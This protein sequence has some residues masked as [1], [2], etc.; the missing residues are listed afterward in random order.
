[1]ILRKDVV[2]AEEEKLAAERLTVA[3]KQLEDLS[4]FPLENPNPVLRVDRSGAIMFANAACAILDLKCQPGQFLPARYRKIVAEVLD[5]GSPQVIEAAGKG[6]IFTL[7]F[8]PVTTAGYVNIYGSDITAWKKAEEALR[9]NQQDLNRAQAVA[10]TGSWRLDVQR[11]ELLWSDETYRMFGI[12]KETPMTYETFL[13]CVHPDDRENVDR[14]WQAALQ[15]E[16]YDIE[17][18]IM[19]GD[20]VKWVRE[21]AEVEFDKRGMLKGG[22]GKVQDITELKKIDEMKDEFIGLVSHELRTPLAL[23]IGSLRSAMSA[24]ISTEDMSELL[25]NAAEGAESLVAILENML[26]LSRFQAD[27]LN[28][29]TETVSIPDVTYNVIQKLKVQGVSQRFLA[30]LP[31]DLPQVK[32]DPTRV[33]RILYNLLE[34]AAKY[35]PQESEIK[36]SAGEEGGFVIIEVIDQGIGIS[37][38]DQKRLF[39]QFQQLML[40]Q[41]GRGVGLGLVV[42]KRLVEAQGGWIKVES[43]VGKGSTFSFALPIH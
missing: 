25:Q 1:M 13:S 27:R 17:H 38:D 43:E 6:R 37:L 35:S 19:V 10:Q 8:V 40:Q 41:S 4:G 5:K 26:E 7:N 31:A 9:E 24:G 30:D 12:P 33:G 15:G 32:A 28:L 2:M 18:R 29:H 11:D 22:F 16:D 39:E 3:N 34:N 14:A 21:R 23:I 20:A 42:C 36:V